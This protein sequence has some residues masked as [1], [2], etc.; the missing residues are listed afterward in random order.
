M[1][2]SPQLEESSKNNYWPVKQAYSF[3]DL[4]GLKKFTKIMGKCCDLELSPFVGHAKVSIVNTDRCTRQDSMGFSFLEEFCDFIECFGKS[5]CA[6][7]IEL[8]YMQGIRSKFSFGQ[9]IQKCM[10]K[11]PNLKSFSVK[12]D[13]QDI[14]EVNS[15]FVV[16]SFP[17]CISTLFHQFLPRNLDSVSLNMYENRLPSLSDLIINKLIEPIYKDQLL[18]FKTSWKEG[19]KLK[20]SQLRELTLYVTRQ[21]GRFD[22]ERIFS[23]EWLEAPIEKFCLKSEKSNC[24]EISIFGLLKMMDMFPTVRYLKLDY[25][26]SSTTSF[27]NLEGF[28][29]NNIHTLE[30][31]DFYGDAKLPIDL[32]R[33]FPKLRYLRMRITYDVDDAQVK[34][35]RLLRS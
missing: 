3:L 17:L 31:T 16:Y 11:C 19:L 2:R 8:K 9:S 1:K 28:R 4:K 18:K 33:A 12:M 15:G 34:S 25:P 5:L 7:K 27:D 32:L 10:H 6:L 20:M 21:Q 26:I 24:P 14:G 29:F 35:V 23:G 30:I 22:F 13:P